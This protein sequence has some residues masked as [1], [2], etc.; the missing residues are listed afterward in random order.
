MAE[1]VG[2]QGA[3]RAGLYCRVSSEE[4]RERQSIESQV[5]F[6]T[7]WFDLYG[8]DPVRIYRDDGVR[9]VV[10]LEDRPAGAQLLADLAAGRINAVY[11]FRVDRLARD[12]RLLLSAVHA[13]ESLGARLVSLTESFDTASPSGRAMLG[14]LAV[15]AQYER[16]SIAERSMSGRRRIALEGR[17]GGGPRPPF[18]Y[19]VADG[20]L[21]PRE[22]LLPGSLLS[23]AGVV[24]LVYQL[25]VT[26]RQSCRQIAS[27]LNALGISPP[28]AGSTHPN[29]RS[30][31]LSCGLW[32]ASRIR[33]LIVTSTYGG[34][35]RWGKR[36]GAPI[37]APCAPLVDRE[38][39]ERAQEQLRENRKTPR[40]QAREYLL[41]GLLRCECGY[42]L[43]GWTPR[44]SHHYY[45]CA[46]RLRD[47]QNG[48]PRCDSA[49]VPG[50]YEEVVWAEAQRVV[51]DPDHRA[52]IIAAAR[53][54][55]AAPD[56]ETLAVLDAGLREHAAAR[57]R[58]LGLYR[59][60]RIME[61]D[62]DSQLDQ[63]EREEQ[64]LRTK[65]G[66]LVNQLTAAPLPRAAD[67]WR[68]LQDRCREAEA[69]DM[70]R[71]FLV[72]VIEVITI[73]TE[74]LDGSR[75]PVAHIRWRL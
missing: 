53:V 35:Q 13:L 45:V 71:A 10:P 72:E 69:T 42:A 51:F 68:Q 16:D 27:H 48:Q 8:I 49:L 65:R 63:L 22:E 55:E 54:P 38:T 40:A 46:A 57:D 59:R 25:L 15:F 3:I 23:E 2:V 37:S 44:P 41:R 56:P 64:A 28:Q 66:A 58:I 62:L 31:R 7:R 75:K 17:W 11:V 19:E 60:G 1:P 43:S 6:G 18:G 74:R 20:L 9:G 30:G 67:H 61:A 36:S 50:S 12:I 29:P 39:W 73:A 34:T 52:A 33:N 4:Q 70:R 47:L 32:S 24:R 5:D 26:E 21:L 14:M